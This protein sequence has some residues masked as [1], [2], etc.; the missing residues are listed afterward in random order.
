MEVRVSLHCTYYCTKVY[1]IQYIYE[2]NFYFLQH[3]VSTFIIYFEFN[4]PCEAF[5]KHSRIFDLTVDYSGLYEG[6]S[7]SKK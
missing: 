5:E 4:Y 3:F 1:T 2:I 7:N 6:A